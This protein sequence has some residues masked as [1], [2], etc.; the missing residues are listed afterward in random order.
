MEARGVIAE[1]LVV[2]GRQRASGGSPPEGER[3]E[4]SGG[5]RYDCDHEVGM[6]VGGREGELVVQGIPPNCRDGP[7]VLGGRSLAL[8]GDTQG[9]ESNAA[10]SLV[11]SS[12]C[13]AGLPR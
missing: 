8:K 3:R 7:Q 9:C 2:Q 6:V 5:T 1:G 11:V 4:D 10:G 13:Y 12:L